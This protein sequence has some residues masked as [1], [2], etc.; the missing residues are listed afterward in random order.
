[1]KRKLINGVE[2]PNMVMATNWMDYPQLKTIMTAGFNAGFRAID[3]ARD[4]GNEAIVGKVLQ[5]VLKEIG[6]QREDIFV[7]TKIGNSQQRKGDIAHEIEISLNNLRTDYIDL[8]LM[9][10]PSRLFHRHMAQDGRGI[11]LRK[12]EGYWHGQL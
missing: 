2:M 1:M 12:G 7:T 9:H 4:Y 11:Q 10:W 6:L 3:T 5:D 8:W